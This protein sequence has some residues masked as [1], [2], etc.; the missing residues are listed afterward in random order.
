MA[1]IDNPRISIEVYTQIQSI[2]TSNKNTNKNVENEHEMLGFCLYTELPIIP[3]CTI[4]F[5]YL[6]GLLFV[7][8][9]DIL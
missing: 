3:S 8:A 1:V 4:F 5:L 2:K 9:M 6:D 7:L